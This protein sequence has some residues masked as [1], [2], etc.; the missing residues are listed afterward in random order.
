MLD[1]LYRSIDLL[2]AEEA[3]HRANEVRAAT[4]LTNQAYGRWH[5]GRQAAARPL[6]EV[7]PVI[8]RPEA[9]DW[10]ERE[11]IPYQIAK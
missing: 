3:T 5:S 4:W 6:Q 1:I 9:A 10:F 2:R 7:A 8:I 11:G